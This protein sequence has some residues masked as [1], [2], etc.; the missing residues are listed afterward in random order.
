M[1]PI[2]AVGFLCHRSDFGFATKSYLR[3]NLR[4]TYVRATD[5]TRLTAVITKGFEII[6]FIEGDYPIIAGVISNKLFKGLHR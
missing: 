3:A 1:P 2:K 6:S 4:T 5:K